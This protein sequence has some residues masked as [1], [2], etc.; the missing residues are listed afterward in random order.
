MT[1]GLRIARVP[2][3][4]P[5][6]GPRAIAI[7]NFDGVHIGH[8]Q[9]LGSIIETGL[10]STVVTFDPNPRAFFGGD[11]AEI[12]TLE[13]RLELLAQTGVDEVL[14]LRFDAAMAAL[15]P[16]LWVRHY[17]RPLKTRLVAV[18]EDFRFGRNRGGDV[19]LLR[20]MGLEVRPVPVVP[21][22]SSTRIRE[23]VQ[24][25]E[26]SR[27]ARLLGRCHQL[28]AD[29]VDAASDGRG[30]TL[31]LEPT[32]RR[33]ALPPSGT[34][35]ARLNERPA[36]VARTRERIQLRAQL[37]DWDG[38]VGDRLRIALAGLFQPRLV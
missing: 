24:R 34:Y 32:G 25:G 19:A 9:V 12:T 10:T 20:R 5:D 2:Q 27:A 18:G 38:A 35:A 37:R 23:L 29:V 3:E 14:V 11:L 7:G 15:E 6:I 8:R 22:V 33:P 30:T 1:R 28:D 4:L 13:H 36:L 26:L 31:V 17:L 16:E 21:D